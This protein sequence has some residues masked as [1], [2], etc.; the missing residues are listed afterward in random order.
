MMAMRN[1]SLLWVLTLLAACLPACQH[2]SP[3]T[4]PPDW[5]YADLRALDLADNIPP[6]Q[7]LIAL[8]I[9]RIGEDV[10]IR[11]DLLDISTS[12]DYD[13]LLRLVSHPGGEV[14]TIEISA[15]GEISIKNK[16]GDPL[17]GVQPRVA[18]D[19]FL[20]TIVV[21]SN[22]ASLF[23]NNLP[24]EVTA[25]STEPNSPGFL[26]GY[27]GDQIGPVRSDASPPQQTEVLFAFW[28]TFSAS[29]PAQALRMWD[30]AHS[31]PGRTRFGLRYL[32]KAVN[33]YHVPV[34]LLDLKTPASLSN[35]D[36]MQVLPEIQSLA[37]R[38]IVI[39]PDVARYNLPPGAI[40]NLPKADSFKFSTTPFLYTS[41]FSNQVYENYRVL[42]VSADTLGTTTFPLSPYRWQDKIIIP[43]PDDETN[44]TSYA[45]TPEGPSL[46]LRRDLTR[47]ALDPPHG[48]FLLG[49][50][51][52]QTAW[53]DPA[54]VAPT[55]QY[56]SSH[57]WIHFI[58]TDNLLTIHP[59]E[60]FP[61]DRIKEQPRTYIADQI[62]PALMNAPDNLITDQ[63]WQTYI[64]LLTPAAPDLMELREGY[65]GIVG[66]LLTAARWASRPG[67]ITDCTM[68][69]DWDEQAECILASPDFFAT[70]E[71]SGG[72]IV[73]AFARREGSVHQIIAPYGQLVVGL[74]DPSTWDPS[75]GSEGDP[76]LVPGGFVDGARSW[77]PQVQL[78]QITFV[79]ADNNL[80]K[81]FFLIEAGLR[82]EY[83]STSPMKVQISLGLDPWRRFFPGWGDV[84]QESVSTGSWEWTLASGPQ[85]TITSS[86]TIIPRA[87]TA[88]RSYL[89]AVEDPN[90]E[91]P[92]GHYIPFPLALVEINS[93]DNFYIQ[94]DVR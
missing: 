39:L 88:S 41:I 84:Y 90:F 14:V 37:D 7:D 24:F 60:V 91:Y 65:F 23:H 58:T 49:G 35:L 10:E 2:Q 4:P 11:L 12:L 64:S 15:S 9:R 18:R 47:Y 72:Y 32:L 51:F 85:V 17:P 42:F 52:A 26:E 77:T 57:P 59:R 3:Y 48:L 16:D 31:G 56:L 74:G 92:P 87:F 86:R 22:R 76:G 28:D 13:L 5:K 8:Y 43:I 78:G 61:L 54:C 70:F 45:P 55:L 38:Q 21:S 25:Y 50:S 89:S 71:L 94:L 29:T 34:F 82:V 63:A 46:A 19:T 62:L 33:N 66:H 67:S 79:D 1:I 27:Y 81:T 68:D 93:Q 30:G 20:D 36:F 75:R 73:T 44:I 6:A 83:E 40:S 69:I 53:G 80:T